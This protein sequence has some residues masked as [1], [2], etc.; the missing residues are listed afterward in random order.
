MVNNGKAMVKQWQR[1]DKA[2]VKAMV[3]QLQSNGKAVAHTT[4]VTTP[5]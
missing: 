1:N 4:V 3:K 2:M 5:Q